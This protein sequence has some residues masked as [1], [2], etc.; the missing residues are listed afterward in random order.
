MSERHDFETRPVVDAEPTIAYALLDEQGRLSNSRLAHRTFYAA[1]TIKLHV[2]IAVLHAIDRGELDLQDPLSSTRTFKGSD[3]KPFDLRG[4]HVD[5]QFPGAGSQ[6]SLE[7][8]LTAMI[9]RSS[10]E[11]TNMCLSLLGD[12]KAAVE[13]VCDKVEVNRT[14]VERLIGDAMAVRK[15]R[16]NETSAFDLAKTM[17]KLVSGKLLSVESTQF[18]VE[19]L[20]AQEKRLILSVLKDGVDAG[21][22]SGEIEKI[23]HDVAF[24]GTPPCS[25]AI[26]SEGMTADNASETIR[27]LSHALLS[28]QYVVNH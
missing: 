22:K 23:Q 6:I 17:H 1:S 4:D 16:A 19:T 11:A 20:R 28:A 8:V 24:V 7:E 27:A 18:A 10:N 12:Y 26:M 14:K 9:V 25:L 15:G 21:S 3:G 13:K 5:P 2:M